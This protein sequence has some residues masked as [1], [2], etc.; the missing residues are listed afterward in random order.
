MPKRNI[1]RNVVLLG[2]FM[3][4]WKR[5]HDVLEAVR[6]RNEVSDED[7][8][9]FLKIKTGIA[10]Q[11][12]WLAET[13]ES[14]SHFTDEV[15]GT[16][17]LT[18]SLHDYLALS[19]TQIKRIEVQWHNLFILMHGQL[20]KYEVSQ[21]RQRSGSWSILFFK[22]PWTILTLGVLG[23]MVLYYF[24]RYKLIKT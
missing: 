15:M 23:L 1:E 20:G 11:Q 14:Q 24:L 6:K 7:E 3:D 8:E 17:S 16:L 13:F 2:S 21:G 10:H 22:N 19:A 4:L 18:L 5:F 12:A 9:D